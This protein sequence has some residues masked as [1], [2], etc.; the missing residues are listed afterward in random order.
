VTISKVFQQKLAPV[1]QKG[2]K[3]NQILTYC[4]KAQNKNGDSKV[5][6]SVLSDKISVTWLK[7][8]SL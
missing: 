7:S 6:A 5:G 1:G 4:P 3:T 2:V 8:L